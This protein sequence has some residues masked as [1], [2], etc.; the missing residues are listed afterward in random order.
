MLVGAANELPEDE[1][2]DA[3]YDR[4]LLRYQVDYLK[5]D[6]RFLQMLTA[7]AATTRTTV[8]MAELAR[9]RERARAVEIPGAVLRDVAELRNRL[10]EKDV[11][12]SDRRWRHSLDLLRA[13]AALQGRE[14][15]TGDDLGLYCHVLWSDPSE[16][17]LV[18]EGAE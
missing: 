14:R 10:V 18:E 13:R 1:E 17:P 6:F 11:V 5:E 15:V 7:P 3:L 4:F 16:R 12:V 8:G 9:M 2:L